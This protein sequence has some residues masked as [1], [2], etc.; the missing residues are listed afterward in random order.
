MNR[1]DKFI[2]TD[3]PRLAPGAFVVRIPGGL[4]SAAAL[5]Q[6][7]YEAARL[8]GYFGFN[9]NALSDCLRDLNWVESHD[10]VV[11]HSDVPSLTIEDLRNYIEVLA[12]CAESWQPDEQH[13]LSV[14]FP[15]RAR[16]QVL[17]A[18]SRT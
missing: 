8:P 13:S 14:I 9:W 5:L 6:A 4:T 17:A 7:I 2:F 1:A 3:A 18:S 16:T 10:V 11:L 15:S 12:E